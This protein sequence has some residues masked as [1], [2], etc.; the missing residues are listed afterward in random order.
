MKKAIAVLLLVCSLVFTSCLK[1]R[2]THTYTMYQPVYKTMAEVRANIKSNTPRVLERPGK[3]Y[4][5]GN[6]IFL[7]EIDK[8]IHVIDNRNP[9]APRKIAFIDIPGNIDLAVKDNI[10]FAD[11]YT[12][13]VSLDIS[14][15]LHVV[16]KKIIENAFPFR[17][18]ENGFVADSN[19]VIVDWIRKDTTVS[20]DCEGGNVFWRG[21][22]SCSYVLDASPGMNKAAS[23]FGAGI[24][25]SLARFT[26]LNNYLYTVSIDQLNVFNLSTANLPQLINKVNIGWNIETIYPFNDRLFIGSSDGM[27]IFATGNPTAPNK[28]GQFSHVRSCDPVIADDRVAYVTLRTGNACQGLVNRME[29][30][31]IDNISSPSVLKVY[32]L[33]NPHG[34]SKDGNILFVCDASDGLK[35]YKADD[36]ADLKLLKQIHHLDTYDVIAYNK[37][38]LVVAKD[39]LYQFDY[40]NLDNIRLLSKIGF[41]N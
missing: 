31:N 34:L 1:D 17:R 15:P 28:V 14:D 25:G 40:S 39:G 13:M 29:V 21:C 18:Y 8:G 37:I 36:P 6:Y 24:G 12:D 19:L 41:N 9:A 7:N 3:I 11:L 16:V 23:P 35:I 27:F 26:I 32:S 30:L 4:I 38:A 5:R 20:I 10:L 33:T 22:A 2:C